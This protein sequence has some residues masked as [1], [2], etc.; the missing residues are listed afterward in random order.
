MTSHGYDDAKSLADGVRRAVAGTEPGSPLTLAPLTGPGA[1]A[2]LRRLVALEYQAHAVELVA[3]GTLLTRFPAA[4]AA[5]LWVTLGRIV[6]EATPKLLRVADA[7]GMNGADLQRR[8]TDFGAYSFHGTVSWTAMCAS[9]AAAALATHTDMQVYYAG[10]TAVARRL[11]DAD[12][13]VPRPF[14][15][16]YDDPGDDALNEL[17]LA[18]VQDGLD[19]GDDPQEALFHGRR[20]AGSLLE[21]WR[22]TADEKPAGAAW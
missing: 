6:H 11:R 4:P 10:A 12:A 19:R 2:P 1:L 14:L 20:V 5:E 15:D 21:V 3:Y 9:Q 13:P 7:L 8:S 22:A 18:V 16:Y 17:A